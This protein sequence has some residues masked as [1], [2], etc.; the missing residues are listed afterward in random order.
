M[1]CAEDEL[2]S[3]TDWG[4]KLLCSLV[5]LY[6]TKTETLLCFNFG[7]YIPQRLPESPPKF[8]VVALIFAL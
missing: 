4:K 8:H 7:I 5:V 3:L 2:R 6:R 1:L